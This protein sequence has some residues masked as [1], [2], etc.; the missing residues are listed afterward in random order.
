MYFLSD[1]L[2]VEAYIKAVTLEYNEDFIM[3]LENEIQ[4]RGINLEEVLN[5]SD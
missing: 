4:L 5:R 1:N 3:I 2:L